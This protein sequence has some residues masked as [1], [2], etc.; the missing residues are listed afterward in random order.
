MAN[1]NPGPLSL[2]LIRDPT[3]HALAA[4]HSALIAGA[5]EVQAIQAAIAAELKEYRLNCRHWQERLVAAGEGT[6][7]LI[8]SG[9]DPFAVH[10]THALLAKTRSAGASS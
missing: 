1:G 6:D 3:T 10:A 4:F 5:S 8:L 7:K 9:S 2:P